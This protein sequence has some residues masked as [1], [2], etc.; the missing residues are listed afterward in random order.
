MGL[1][2][3]VP[4]DLRRRGADGRTRLRDCNY[5]ERRAAGVVMASTGRVIDQFTSCQRICGP[6][7]RLFIALSSVTTQWR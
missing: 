1:N 3:S 7:C 4:S 6:A 5:S 2:F